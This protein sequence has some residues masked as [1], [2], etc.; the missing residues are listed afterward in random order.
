MELVNCQ[1]VY[2]FTCRKK[3]QHR[4][5]LV[6][7]SKFTIFITLSMLKRKFINKNLGQFSPKMYWKKCNK[8]DTASTLILEYLLH[9][10]LYLGILNNINY[11]GTLYCGVL[12]LIQAKQWSILSV[13]VLCTSLKYN[14]N[15]TLVYLH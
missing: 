9:K 2:M 5:K 8:N 7:Y 3:E 11:V 6:M 12:Y 14:Q 15:K 1:N 10:E 13:D 4:C